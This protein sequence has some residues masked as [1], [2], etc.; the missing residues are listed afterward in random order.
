MV[1]HPEIDELR[2]DPSHT[3]ILTDFDGTLAPIVDDPATVRPQPGAAAV[4]ADLADR[5]AIVGVITGRPAAF[6]EPLVPSGV[7]I[8]GLYGLELVRDGSREEH[9]EADRWRSVIDKVAASAQ[10]DGPAG[11]RVEPKGLSLTLHYRETPAIADDVVAWASDAATRTG[12][13]PRLA[14]M[15]IELHPP[16]AVDK[17]TAL[18]DLVR[19][20]RAACF[21]GDDAGDLRAF[22][23]LDSL[24][25]DGITVTRVA[26]RSD[27]APE[28]LLDRADVVVDGPA[29]A[30]AFLR[31]LTGDR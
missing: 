12:L 29:G 17:G 27:E 4:L 11:M 23:A 13:E 5:Y 19:G 14:R 6:V 9:P 8:A 22:D 15:S 25:R 30:V 2:R 20:M 16:I 26:V 21:L 28:E 3:A 1:A 7:V 24:A 31:S 10:R 18:L